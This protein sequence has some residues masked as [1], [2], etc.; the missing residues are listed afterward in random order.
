MNDDLTI[1]KIRKL[2]KE[3]IGCPELI[4]LFDRHKCLFLRNLTGDKKAMMDIQLSKAAVTERYQTC[5]P[6]F[7]TIRQLPH[8]VIKGAVLSQDAYGSPFLRKSG[9]IDLLISRENLD[10]VKSALLE[11][12]F[13]Q[14][15]LVRGSVVPFTRR[16]LLFQ[17]AMSHQTAPFVKETSNRLCPYANIDVNLDILWGESGQNTDMDY[18]LAH[19]AEAEIAGVTVKR[20]KPEMAFLSLCLHHYKDMNSI[21]LLYKGGLRL[22]LFCDIYYAF[23][24]LSLDL[25]VLQ[26]HSQ[27]LSVAPYL[28][29][30]VYYAN[31]VFDDPDLADF[32]ESWKG[33]R[34]DRLM[35]SFGLTD[36]ERKNW[37][38]PFNER[39][40]TEDIRSLL[41][42]QLDQADREKIA[43]NE[44]FM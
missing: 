32:L 12:G 9:D 30:C 23:K 21:Y 27:R 19:S 1:A 18:V 5:K 35:D 36:S 29:Y 39:L 4:P 42:G 41:D 40:F 6:L 20:L 38:V 33:Y 31:E 34:D 17:T 13:I 25:D 8:A 10:A 43:L 44:R 2:V 14:G 26:Q 28:Y 24:N 3:N 16:E 11:H 7:D 37:H 22:Y 15:K